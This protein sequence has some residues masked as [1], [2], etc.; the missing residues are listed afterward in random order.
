MT[1]LFAGHDTTTSTISFMFYE[2][3]RQPAIAAAAARGAARA[4]ARRRARAPRSCVGGELP[5]LEMTID[6]T[7]RKYPPAWVGPRR[8]VRDV[9]FEGVPIPGAR[10]RQLLLV[11][12]APP[13]R[14]VARAGGVPPGALHAGG[15]GG[16]REGRLRAVR[17]RL[18]DL[19]RDAL[20][21]ARGADDRDGAA[22]RA[23]AR[24]AGRLQ[25]DDPPDADDQPRRR[26]CR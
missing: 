9:D 22:G 2:L 14:R 15:Q 25:A 12:L 26:G 19:H 20:R 1:L 17:R 21:P 18:A 11:G 7:L 3:A 10:V 24:A 13:A 6:E 8:T 23:R 5:E 16:A 4:R